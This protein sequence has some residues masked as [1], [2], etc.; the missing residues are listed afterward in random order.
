MYTS[1]KE[2]YFQFILKKYNDKI[3]TIEIRSFCFPS[4]TENNVE[5]AVSSKVNE[6]W[7]Q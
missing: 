6:C 5:A 2:N 1:E 7:V 3:C 4:N